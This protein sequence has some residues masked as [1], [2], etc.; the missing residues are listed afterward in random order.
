MN[1]DAVNGEVRVLIETIELKD[2]RFRIAQSVFMVTVLTALIIVIVALYTVITRIEG[3]TNRLTNYIRCTSLT[4]I[5]KRTENLVNYC[6]DKSSQGVIS[7]NK[8]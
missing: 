8:K 5:E 2:R 6:F 4:P 7:N 3:N 1:N